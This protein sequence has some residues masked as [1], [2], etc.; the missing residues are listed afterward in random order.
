MFTGEGDPRV[1]KDSPKTSVRAKKSPV[2]QKWRSVWGAKRGMTRLFTEDGGPTV[3]DD[4]ESRH[5]GP[6]AE[7]GY[8]WRSGEDVR[9]KQSRA[10]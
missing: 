9:R 6:Y 7:S 8:R 4:S 1:W 10:A 5:P 2:R 3:I